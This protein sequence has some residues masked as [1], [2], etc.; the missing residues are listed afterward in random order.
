MKI[1]SSENMSKA[2]L[3]TIEN[4]PISSYNL[5]ERAAMACVR[6]LIK[7]LDSDTKVYVACGQGNNGGD[8]LA[9]ARLLQER[10][11]D[12]NALVIFSKENFSPDAKSNYDLFK[13]KFPSRLIDIKT[14]DEL[15]E[16]QFA[17]PSILIDALLGTGVKG[18]VDGFLGESITVFNL[19]FQN[20]ISI[21]LPS[22]LIPDEH[23]SENKNIIHS[24]LT[25]S[26][27]LPKLGLLFRENEKFVRNFEIV[28]I[29][30]LKD[31]L[32]KLP[33]RDHFI[34]KEMI[35]Q[36]LKKRKKHDH[37]G[38]FGHALLL[39]GSQDKP[40][41][42]LISAEACLRSGAGLL[43]VHSV[44]NVLNA[45]SVRIPEAMQ[46]CDSGE[47]CISSLEKTENYDAIAFGPGTGTTEETQTVLKKLLQYYKGKLVI[48]ADGLNILSENKTWLSFLPA[49]TILTPHPKEFERLA[50]KSEND[51]ERLK[52]LRQ[53]SQ[54]HNVI[55]ILKG[56]HAAIAMPDGNVYFNST[57]NP[58]LAKGGSGDAL[59]G[60]IL[61]LLC[62]G[63]NAPQ[64][65]I[66][67]AYLHGYAA[68]LCLKKM[69]MESVLISDVIAL[70]PKAFR[71]LED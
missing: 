3:F 12:V 38:T 53:F 58:G 15:K 25:I 4:E 51:F 2:D 20:I 22:G 11:Y 29:G 18:E 52:M 40:G 70:I 46:S 47:K 39:A 7:I 50:G 9:I 1:L 71:K 16:M 54:K 69:S 33:S 68:D 26:L 64:A 48:D 55:V 61:G 23:C 5:M 31:G 59:T 56:A 60:M 43:T 17:Q 45:L 49:D 42:A 10:G 57:G 6:R 32:E 66:I 65:C 34:T 8:G 13:E 19:M 67:G 14:I 37:K 44:S 28:N 35:T 41:A 63:Y 36:L 62:R 21:D 30:L 27:Q 24:A